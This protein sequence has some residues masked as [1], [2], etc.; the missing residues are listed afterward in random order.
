MEN[1]SGIIPCGHRVLVE[2][3]EVEVTTDSGIVIATA[4]G[5]RMEA[6]AQTI[7]KVIAMGN[8]CYADQPAPWCQVG[9]RITFSKYGGLL[10]TGKDGKKYRVLN[11]LDIVSIVEEGVK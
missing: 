3:E 2:P 8:T 7:G 1:P 5:E 9:D 11:D 6:M 10:N 4:S